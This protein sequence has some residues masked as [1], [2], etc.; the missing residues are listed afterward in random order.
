MARTRTAVS[1]PTPDDGDGANRA[2]GPLQIQPLRIGRLSVELTGLSPLMQLRFSAKAIQAM[3]SKQEA[4]SQAKKGT[5][6]EARDFEA[7]YQAAAHRFVDGSIGLPASA[8]RSAC[9][10]ACR[11]AGFKMTIAKMSLFIL[12]D[13]EDQVDGTPLVKI[14]GKPE[15][16]IL[17]VRNATG[18]ADLRA[19]PLWR[20]WSVAVVVEFDR[21]QF[22]ESDI[23]NLLVRAGRQVGVGEGR[24]DSKNSAGLGYGTFSV[25]LQEGENL[26]VTES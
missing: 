23:Y 17:P 25:K 6:R 7:D 18:V 20:K 9:I 11:L 12:A 24:P 5:K 10:S 4:G 22:S 16:S 15:C 13:G 2:P 14:E 8:L 21:D 3:R 26:E 1:T 19:R